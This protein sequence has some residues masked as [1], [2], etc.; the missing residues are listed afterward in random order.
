MNARKASRP[1]RPPGTRSSILYC[2]LPFTSP[3]APPPVA[4]AEAVTAPSL[5]LPRARKRSWKKEL[6]TARMQRWTGMGGPPSATSTSASLQSSS[7]S[8]RRRSRLLLRRFRLTASTLLLLPPPPPPPPPPHP[9]AA[10]SGAR[11]PEQGL[12]PLDR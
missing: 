10:G 8:R 2:G 1:T 5:R 11:A 4:E 7:E 12:E 3:P 6:R 9:S